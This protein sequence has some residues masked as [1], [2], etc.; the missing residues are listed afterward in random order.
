MLGDVGE[1]VGQ[2]AEPAVARVTEAAEGPIQVMRPIQAVQV[3]L[4][5]RGECQV[6]EYRAALWVAG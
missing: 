2:V 3:M 5:G 1:L 6:Q 4:E